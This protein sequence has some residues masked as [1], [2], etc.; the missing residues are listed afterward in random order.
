MELRSIGAAHQLRAAAAAALVCIQGE[1]CFLSA[2]A[3]RESEMRREGARNIRRMRERDRERAI[4]GSTRGME[5][6]GETA[7]CALFLSLSLSAA[8]ERVGECV[9]VSCSTSCVDY[10][11]A[12][13]KRCRECLFFLAFRPLWGFIQ[14]NEVTKFSK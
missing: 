10:R 9:V 12:F 14:M 4:R 3:G 6:W 11:R 2:R 5:N 7:T 1:F 8:H 13:F